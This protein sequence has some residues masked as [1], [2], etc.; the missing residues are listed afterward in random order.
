[1]AAGAVALVCVAAAAA[2]AA[3]TVAITADALMRSTLA[4]LPPEPLAIKGELIVRLQRGIILEKYPFE[5]LL[6]WGASPAVA[7]Y[8]LPARG[9]HPREQM[10]LTRS[11]AGRQIAYRRGIAP[12]NAAPPSLTTRI[13]DTDLSWLDLTLDF[14]WWHHPTIVGE[15][16]VRGFD[17]YIV[18]LPRPADMEAEYA[19][20]RLWIGKQ[21]HLLLQ[22]EGVDANGKVVR[23]LWVKS[24]KKID[25]KWIVKEMEIQSY[26]VV[27]RTKLHIL[28]V[29]EATL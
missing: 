25:E 24:C 1:V 2:M 8:M 11:A 6:H 4:Q 21:Q 7:H 17:C 29:I 20:A 28:E 13:R 18:E 23:R 12:T 9:A 27:H 3:P 22:A 10:E 5:C 16:S 14:L 15:E 19:V 26:P